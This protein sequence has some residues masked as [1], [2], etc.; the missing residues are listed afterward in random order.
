[1]MFSP[2]GFT[3]SPYSES[4]GDSKGT[5]TSPSRAWLRL[6]AFLVPI[7]TFNSGLVPKAQKIIYKKKSHFWL[8]Q[9]AQGVTLSV[10]LSVRPAQS[11]LKH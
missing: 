3:Q 1:M 7:L 5:P 2:S 9:G 4:K 10:C 8:R 11:A 6:N